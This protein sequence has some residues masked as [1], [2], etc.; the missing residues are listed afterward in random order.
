MHTPNIRDWTILMCSNYL[1]CAFRLVLLWPGLFC[2]AYWLS[3]PRTGCRTISWACFFTLALPMPCH[4]ITMGVN[5]F[6]SGMISYRVLTCKIKFGYQRVLGLG[7][8]PDIAVQH[9]AAVFSPAAPKRGLGHHEKCHRTE[10]EISEW[11]CDICCLVHICPYQHQPKILGYVGS[12][13][14]EQGVNEGW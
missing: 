14:F 7:M 13:W 6:L 12:K 3:L 10:F 5:H 9:R 4:F 1:L 11:C 8:H 2:F